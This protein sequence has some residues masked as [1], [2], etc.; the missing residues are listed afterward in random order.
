MKYVRTWTTIFTFF[1]TIAAQASSVQELLLTSG[2]IDLKTDTITL[3]LHEGHLKDGRNLWYVLT[4]VSDARLAKK[5][6]LVYAPGLSNASK[7]AGTRTADRDSQGELVFSA[8]S[9]DFSPIRAITPGDSPNLFPPKAAQPGSV[10]DAE[11]SPYVVVGTENATYNAPIL[12]FDVQ[13]SDIS[14]CQ[15]NVD[16]S[17]VHDKVVSICPGTHQVTLKLS[18]GFASAEPLVYLS[19]DANNPVA[20][21]MEAATY[22]P[23]LEQLKGKGVTLKLYAITNG[24]TGTT[25]PNRQGFGSALLGEGSPLNILTGIPTLEDGYSPLWDIQIA[26]W[27]DSAIT[28]GRRHLVTSAGEI[29]QA[30]KSGELGAFGGGVLGSSGIL[31]NCPA[32]AILNP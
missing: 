5:Q 31:V 13:A 30:V 15:G 4:D 23:A 8:G 25:N 28:E 18:H 3:P 10:A 22:V 20:A 32:V 2:R 9:I 16:Y 1:A 27:T 12:A 21:T 6:G 14:F 26:Q 17:R 24:D 19:F 11:Y 29:H 7:V